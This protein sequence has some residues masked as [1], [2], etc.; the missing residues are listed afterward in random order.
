MIS[1]F[2][3]AEKGASRPDSHAGSRG[4]SSSLPRGAGF[5]TCLFISLLFV[6]AFMG[7][8]VD[9]L[10]AGEGDS[11]FFLQPVVPSQGYAT[12]YIH[13][14][15]KSPVEDY[16]RV[17]D[18]KIWSWQEKVRTHNAGL[19]FSGPELGRFY[20]DPPWMVVEGGRQAWERLFVRIGDGEFGRN[21]FLTPGGDWVSLYTRY[22]GKR[23]EFSVERRPLMH[24]FFLP[25]PFAGS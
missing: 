22:P 23:L 3:A 25:A 9:V 18:G 4:G 1:S 19:P 16:Y 6:A 15:E 21:E 11:V 14:V 20:N 5:I 10:R 8:P 2:P 7:W 12:R 24:L 13:S 17:L